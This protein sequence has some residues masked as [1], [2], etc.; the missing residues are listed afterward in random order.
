MLPLE[1]PFMHTRT[2]SHPAP[3]AHHAH[4]H[5]HT[6]T[7]TQPMTWHSSAP[8][9]DC[10]IL[11]AFRPGPMQ[12]PSHLLPR[13]LLRDSSTHVLGRVLTPLPLVASFSC[14]PGPP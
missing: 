5:K 12:V 4:T 1:G 3:S 8:R 9:H 7:H 6:N 14:S 11:T 2:R 10:C 13:C